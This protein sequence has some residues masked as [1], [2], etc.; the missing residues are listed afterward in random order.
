MVFWQ[1]IIVLFRF[2]VSDY[3]CR[4]KKSFHPNPNFFK[5]TFCVFQEKDRKEIDGLLLQYESKSGSCYYYTQKG[6]Y[7]LSNHWGRLANS[8]WRLVSMEPET[9][10]RIKLGFAKWSD[11][12][13]DNATERL[14]YI[15]ADFIK[16]T[17][18]YQH[19]NNPDF[20]NKAILRTS[21]ETTKRLKQIRNLFNLTSW[22][23]YLD[24]DDLD[25]LRKKI[26]EQLIYTNRTLE[27]IK[28][29]I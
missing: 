4:M 5:N 17:A 26:I 8:K 28:R 14:Y 6:M 3:L 27:E 19:K 21:S 24:Y 12:Y 1:I 15:E 10:S 9:K 7:R 29:E 22:S 25:V 16:K 23:K 11:F 20:D 2:T 13:P 18:N